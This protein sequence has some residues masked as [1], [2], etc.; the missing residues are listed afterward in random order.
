VGDANR[1]NYAFVINFEGRMRRKIVYITGTRADYGLMKSTLTEI[2][3]REELELEIVV[4]GMHLMADFGHTIDL[5][6]KDGFKLHRVDDIYEMD[7]KESM[8][9]FVGRF[10]TSLTEKIAEINP[11]IILLLGDRGEMLAGA[12]V[13]AYLSIAVAHIHGGDISSTVD[14]LVRNAITKLAQIHFPATTRSAKRITNMGEDPARVFVVGAPGLDAIIDDAPEDCDEIAMRYGLDRNSP[15]LL[16]VQHPVTLESECSGEQIEETMQAISE[17]K[18]QTVIIYPNSDAGGRKMI[19][20]IQKYS[21]NKYLKIYKNIDRKDYLGM[22]TI[23]SAIIG[24]SSSAIIEAP[25]FNLPAINIGT[26]QKGRERGCNVIDA[27]YNRNEIRCAIQR[28]LKDNEF[29]EK[30]HSSK[31]PYGDGKSSQKIADIL[32]KI[33]IDEGLM[34]KWI[35][36]DP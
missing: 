12:I 26:R 34:Q 5:I 13:G 10:I 19:E 6:E 17:L 1:L 14:D 15:I 4:T 27:G 35:S 22:M 33:K 30:I 21:H 23:A 3:K 18:Y 8:S 25:S 28:A 29:R 2:S 7:S 31:N 9:C 16:V 11:D 24:N 32:A 36:E 20:V